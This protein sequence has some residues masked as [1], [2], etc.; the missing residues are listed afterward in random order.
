[1]H[2][3]PLAN[4]VPGIILVLSFVMNGHSAAARS[5]PEQQVYI[6][7]NQLGFGPRAVKIAIA[8]ADA[9]LPDSF[10]VVNANTKKVAFTGNSIPIRSKVSRSLNRIRLPLFRTNGLFTTTM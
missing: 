7:V 3:R 8:F 5:T 6:R 2:L 1:M 10:Q 4:T 9:P